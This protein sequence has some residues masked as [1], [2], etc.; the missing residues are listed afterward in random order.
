MTALTAIAV[1]LAGLGHARPST[2]EAM[3]RFHAAYDGDPEIHCR[4]KTGEIIVCARRGRSPYRLPLPDERPAIRMA[5]E[6]PHGA[7]G[8]SPAR[9]AP[10][11]GLTLTIPIGKG[12]GQ[13]APAKASLQGTGD[14]MAATRRP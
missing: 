10:G 4:E 1:L 13:A 5:G 11:F 2:M 9:I 7:V 3:A 6:A 12:P 14:A 8:G